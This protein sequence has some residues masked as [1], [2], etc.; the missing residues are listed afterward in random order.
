ML[1]QGRILPLKFCEQ[2]S[3]P[4]QPYIL[5]AMQAHRQNT[6]TPLQKP[7]DLAKSTDPLDSLRASVHS[8][9]VTAAHCLPVLHVYLLWKGTEPST[10]SGCGCGEQSTKALQLPQV[11]CSQTSEGRCSSAISKLSGPRHLRQWWTRQLPLLVLL[12]A[13]TAVDRYWTKLPSNLYGIYSVKSRYKWLELLLIGCIK[14]SQRVTLQ[15]H[16]QPL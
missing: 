13:L 9:T 4:P 8:Y 7:P 12:S 3:K 10:V 6:S 15:S 14:L 11:C 16:M 2:S 5:S 1:H